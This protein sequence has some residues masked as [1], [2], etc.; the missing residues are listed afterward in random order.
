MEPEFFMRPDLFWFLLGL[1]LLLLELIIPGFVV[2][3]F[4]IGA[5]ITA[6]VCLFFNPGL[7]LQIIIFSITSII[8]LV[9]LR[10]MLT[11]RFF[12]QESSSP[13]TLEDEFI[14]RE[15]V[16]IEDIL[17]GD[18]G[19]VEFKGTPWNARAEDDIKKGQTVI[20]TGKDSISLI[21]KSKN[22]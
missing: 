17:K 19:K 15:A 18:K 22:K 11:R 1:A 16:S 3:F 13:A 2:F 9:L 4:G 7:D 5:W 14:G 6:L 12:K 10:N 8:S 21:I 20:I